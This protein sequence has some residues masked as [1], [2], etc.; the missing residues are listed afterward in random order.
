MER[1]QV[2]VALV[3]RL[4][5][6]QCVCDDGEQRDDHNNDHPSLDAEA[7]LQADVGYLMVRRSVDE[8]LFIHKATGSCVRALAKTAISQQP[9]KIVGK[10]E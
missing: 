6:K 3:G 2:V 10:T 8:S 7:E 4:Q 1:K 9:P 5:S